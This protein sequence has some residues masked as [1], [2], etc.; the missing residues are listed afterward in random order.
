MIEALELLPSKY[1][2]L[3]S[4]PRTIKKKLNYLRVIQDFY[5]LIYTSSYA[6]NF[7]ILY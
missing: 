3:S 2:A 6:P 1:N 7:I 5:D 4:N